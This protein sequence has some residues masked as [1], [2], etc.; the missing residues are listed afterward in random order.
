MLSCNHSLKEKSDN[1]PDTSEIIKVDTEFSDYS[2]KN[3]MKAAFLKYAGDEAV[4]LRPNGYPI[5]GIE[6]IREIMKTR[7]DSVFV[8]KWQPMKAFVAR[9]G[10]LAYT[11]GT[12]KLTSKDNVAQGTYITIWRKMDG[13]WKFV[14]DAGNEGLG[15]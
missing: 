1:P 10:E 13:E 5:E 9:S 14:L 11:Y 15:N 4:M 6:A 2:V 7:K 3:G 8:L 12:Y